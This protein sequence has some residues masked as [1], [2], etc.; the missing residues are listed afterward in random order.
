[1]DY[2][3]ILKKFHLILA[4]KTISLNMAASIILFNIM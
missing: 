2:K 3:V 1:M 4:E